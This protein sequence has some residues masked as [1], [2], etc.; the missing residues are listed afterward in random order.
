MRR[1]LL[2]IVTGLSLLLSVA[3]VGLWIESYCAYDYFIVSNSIRREFVVASGTGRIGFDCI[4]Y[5]SKKENPRFPAPYEGVV[6]WHRMPG[7]GE[8]DD[9]GFNGWA[10]GGFHVE[11]DAP[12]Y[13]GAVSVSGTRQIG[14]INDIRFPYWFLTLA[15]GLTAI[16]LLRRALRLWRQHRRRRSGCCQSCGYDLR[17]HLPGD[18]CPECGTPIPTGFVKERIT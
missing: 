13:T 16:W 1:W 9:W 15:T 17:A 3:T 14:T 8:L 10:W 5:D 11:R 7:W 4:V 6:Q 18:R 12:T 2:N